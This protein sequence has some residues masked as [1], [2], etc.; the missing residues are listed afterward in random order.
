MDGLD[1]VVGN[2]YQAGHYA[3]EKEGGVRPALQLNLSATPFATKNTPNGDGSLR[4][5]YILAEKSLTF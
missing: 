1:G 3:N 2:I 5:P 4:S